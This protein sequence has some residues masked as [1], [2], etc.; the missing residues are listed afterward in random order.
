MR[1]TRSGL[2]ILAAMLTQGSVI[3]QSRQ[4]YKF[5]DDRGQ[6]VYSQAPP[7]DARP[8]KRIDLAPA[9]AGS[10]GWVP[11]LPAGAPR[12]YSAADFAQPTSRSAGQRARTGPETSQRFAE[13]EA[14]CNRQ[15]GVDCG[16]PRHLEYL[17][18]T[19]IPRS[20][21][22]IVRRFRGDH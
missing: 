5:N 15:R 9:Y 7:S 6:V 10:A 12:A 3:A 19:R 1:C 4:A 17:D 14:E 13:L 16:D 22:I 18:T 11:P 21:P 8:A 2:M 20:V